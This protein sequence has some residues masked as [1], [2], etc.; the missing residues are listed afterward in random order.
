MTIRKFIR[1]LRIEA[2]K[3]VTERGVSVA[4]ARRDPAESVPRRWMRAA[5]VAPVTAFPGNGQQRAGLA[6]IAV[7]T[8]ELARLRA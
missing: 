8:T 6:E 3:P 5:S 2:V 4:Q 1:E 7:L